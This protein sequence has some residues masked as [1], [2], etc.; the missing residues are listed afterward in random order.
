MAVVTAP[1]GRLWTVNRRWDPDGRRP[2][3][4]EWAGDG[5]EGLELAG[6][7]VVVLLVGAV[8]V[9]I[10]LLLLVVVV[11]AAF[12]GR[13]WSNHPW[14]VEA[15]ASGDE[16]LRGEVVGWRASGRH[17]ARVAECL[18]DGLPLPS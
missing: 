3:V 16:T 11:V 8:L 12:V 18:R 2:G 5:L 7:G 15:H 6:L 13:T 17:A 1:D 14:T 10:E 9:A 4:G